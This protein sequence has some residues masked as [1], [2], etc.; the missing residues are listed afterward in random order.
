MFAKMI[1]PL[2]GGAPA[3]WNVCMVFFQASLLAG[4]LYAHLAVKWMGVRRQA[5]LHVS[6]LLLPF[7]FMLPMRIPEGWL[8]PADASPTP[9]LLKVLLVAVGL[10]F[11]LVS[12]SAPML[13]KWFSNTDH[14]SARDPYFL[15]VASNL[16]SM[17]GL[18]AYPIVL[19]PSLRLAEQSWMWTTG[20][21]VL[22]LLTLGCGVIL[23]SRPLTGK[24]GTSLQ[25]P[26]VPRGSPIVAEGP[27]T[28]RQKMKWVVLSFAPSSLLLAVT[29][30]LSTDIVAVPLLW[31]I[32]LGLYLFSFVLVFA[33][34]ELLSHR[35]MVRRLPFLILAAAITI[36]SHATEPVWLLIPLHLLTFFVA[37]MVCHGELARQRPSARYLTEFYLWISVGGVL[38]GLFNA[39]V[40]PVL[41]NQVLEYPLALV[42]ASLL[43]R[44][45]TSLG[46]ET[47]FKRW[48]DFL[49]PLALGVVTLGLIMGLQ[50]SRLPSR[51]LAHVLIFGLS[52]VAC[53]SFAHRPIRFG[54][55]VSALMLASMSYTGPYGNFLHT[56]RSFFGVHRIMLDQDEKYHLLLH[57]T[58]IHG[59]QS[60]DPM[61]R[62]QPLAYYYPT[63]PIGQLFTTLRG[64]LV[65]P[66]IA[67]VGLGSGSLACYGDP[68]Q[69]WN[70]YEIDPIVKRLARDP[71]YFTYLR[72]CPPRVLVTLGDARLSLTKA[73]DSHFGLI[74]LD[75]FSSDAIPTHLLT[76]EAVELYLSKLAKGGIIALHISNRHINLRPVI[77]NLAKNLRLVSLFRDDMQIDETEVRMGKEP[78]TW[79]VMAHHLTDLGPLAHDP[80]WKPLEEPVGAVWTDDFSNIV[81]VINWNF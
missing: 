61:R 76:R 39:L 44:P 5:A 2:L 64:R 59:A 81:T 75:A 74:V 68:H 36:F 18:L 29:A 71:K 43:L 34:K 14:P 55:G 78:S 1:L 6:L 72:D 4:Y 52:S 22:A 7:F 37:A 10:P 23:W 16:G 47:T 25:D 12:A 30:H 15:Y 51:R 67:V 56:E 50:A 79:A 41:F 26:P 40:A 20:Y 19:E 33:K 65:N 45:A 49:M 13:Q 9:W 53:L 28:V 73:P 48:L 32:P 80:R 24:H 70:F 46:V 31:V 54:L 62:L 66:R 60:L 77:G 42:V 27:L 8:P 3:V 38:G 21:E 63:G 17:V 58:T 69:F 35:W 57:G 11:L